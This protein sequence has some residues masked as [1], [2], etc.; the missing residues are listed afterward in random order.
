[1]P[2]H[3]A[4]LQP[5]PAT[6]PLSDAEALAIATEAYHYFYPLISM[7]VTRRQLTNIEAGKMPGRGPANTF[8]HMRAFP[9]AEFKEVVRPNFDTLY[10]SAWLDLTAEPIVISVPHTAGRYYLLPMLDMWSDVFAVPGKR[11]SGTDAGSFVIVGPGWSGTIPARL[12]RIDAPT[13]HVWVI[14]RTQ[15][16]GPADYA[17]VHKVQDG[18]TITTLSNWPAKTAY[19]PPPVAIDPTVDMKTPPKVQVD[20]MKGEAYFAYAADLLTSNPPHITDWSIVARMRRIG[21]VPGQSFDSSSVDPAILDRAVAAAQRT[22]AEKVATLARIQ[23]GWQ[24]NTDS[25]GVYGN[26][27]LKRAIVA[28]VGLGANQPEDAIYPLCVADADGKP[29]V[30]EN[31]YVIHFE[32]DQLPPVDAFWSITMYDASGFQVANPINRFAIGDRD[33]LKRNADGS[34]DIYIQNASPGPDKESNW[35]PAAASGPIGVT[36]RLY[37]PR[38]EALDGRWAPPAV[39]RSN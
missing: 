29:L 31:N 3:A 7:D 26:F 22:M 33:A 15:T 2:P 30:A 4:A 1:M 5:T 16:N 37:A 24:M 32:K 36:M 23:N 21:I 38:A 12:E 27:Y 18:F 8:S 39:R 13:S 17:N 14:G 19:T 28:A 10:S 11:T 35:L 20:T 9:T 25:M 6:A 34:I